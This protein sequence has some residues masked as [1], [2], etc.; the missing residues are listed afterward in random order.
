LVSFWSFLMRFKASI[1]PILG[2]LIS[3]N[4][5]GGVKL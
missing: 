4:V 3:N 2:M 1:P 5:G